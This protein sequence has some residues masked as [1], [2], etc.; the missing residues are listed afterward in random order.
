MWSYKI[1]TIRNC[2]VWNVPYGHKT[3]IKYD[4][5][6]TC[7]KTLLWNNNCI[8]ACKHKLQAGT[9]TLSL[10][11]DYCNQR[12][13][14]NCIII[15]VVIISSKDFHLLYMSSWNLYIALSFIIAHF[16][17]HRL[18]PPS[19]T[20][21][22]TAAAAVAHTKLDDKHTTKPHS[23]TQHGAKDQNM[24]ENISNVGCNCVG[25]DKS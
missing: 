9:Y 13:S 4:Y 10:I 15:I 24:N 2:G 20:S 23:D 5:V 1:D 8:H 11:A 6:Y 12:L 17:Y 25:L 3:G 18:P 21:L 16:I 22:T 19:G 7:K 14:F